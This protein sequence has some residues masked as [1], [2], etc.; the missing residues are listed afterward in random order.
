MPYLARGNQAE[1]LRAFCEQHY[2]RAKNDLATVFLERCL[3]LCTEGGTASLVLPQNWMFL[4]SC[5]QLRQRLLKTETW[6]LLARL[7]AGAFETVT[8]EVVKAILLSLSRGHPYGH[9]DGL[10]AD[11]SAPAAMRGLDVSVSRTASEKATRI[12]ESEIQ[13]V[14][15]SRQLTN[16][17]T[18]IT[19]ED[20]TA[21]ARLDDYCISIEGLTTGDLE[22]FVGKFWE[23]ALSDGWQ[24]LGVDLELILSFIYKRSILLSL[25]ISID[26]R[27][28]PYMTLCHEPRGGS[29]TRRGS[30]PL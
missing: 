5:R 11:D 30:D 20:T 18:R 9:S 1:P 24:A 2:P 21:H 3:R 8:G 16:P 14:E 12:R 19:L 29:E 13:S 23:G 4:T 28:R 15:H 22:R 17:D 10:V 26:M 25:S 27:L 6:H 7:G